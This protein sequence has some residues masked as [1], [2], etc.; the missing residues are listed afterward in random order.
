AIGADVFLGPNFARILGTFGTA[1]ALGGF[2]GPLLGGYL[3]DTTQSYTI[4]MVVSAA[5]LFASGSLVWVVAPRKGEFQPAR[6]RETAPVT[7]SSVRATPSG[8][9]AGE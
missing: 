9:E 1:N 3:F 8:V 4:A 7:A 2:M 6:L 5:T